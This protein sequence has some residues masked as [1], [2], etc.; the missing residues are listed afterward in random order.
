MQSRNTFTNEVSFFTMMFFKLL[1]TSGGV[2]YQIAN[3]DAQ[4]KSSCYT[5]MWDLQNVTFLQSTIQLTKLCI[6]KPQ[7]YGF[8]TKANKMFQFK[9]FYCNT[10]S[11]Y[12]ISELTKNIYK[13]HNGVVVN[14]FHINLI[15]KFFN[16]MLTLLIFRDHNVNS[17]YLSLEYNITKSLV[18]LCPESIYIVALDI[19]A[20]CI[21]FIVDLKFELSL[22]SYI[23]L[24]WAIQLLPYLFF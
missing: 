17:K 16:R 11:V 23:V 21:A 19:V 10:A 8:H 22:K 18:R 20:C 5:I 7:P 24:L 1:E 2:V 4:V 14:N 12:W 15:F 13:I 6:I 9:C 3:D